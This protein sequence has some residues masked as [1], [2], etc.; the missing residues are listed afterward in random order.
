M[1]DRALTNARIV[2]EAEVAEGT[3]TCREGASPGSTRPAPP[4]PVA[5][6]LTAGLGDRRSIA[7]G[8]HADLVRVA[9]VQH[10]PVVRVVWYHGRQAGQGASG[11]ETAPSPFEWP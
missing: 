10:T 7:P 11:G 1:T 2:L 5:P 3:V 4:C 8:L 6:I 9:R